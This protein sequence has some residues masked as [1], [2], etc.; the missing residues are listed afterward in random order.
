MEKINIWIK[1]ALFLVTIGAS[2]ATL[3]NQVSNNSSDI[4]ECKTNAKENSNNML[5]ELKSMNQF[6]HSIDNKTTRI[7]TQIET[8]HK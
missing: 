2:Y 6:L 1:I 4:A 8:Y 5:L 3:Q 7:E